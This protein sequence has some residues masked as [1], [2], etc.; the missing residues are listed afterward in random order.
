MGRDDVRARLSE[1]KVGKPLHPHMISAQRGAVGNPKTEE[2]KQ[3]ASERMRKIW[4][5]P[6]EHGL[7]ARRRWTDE[8]IAVLGTDHDPVI[9]ERLGVAPHIVEQK[10]RRLRIP[11]HV[12][13]WSD[14]EIALLGTNTDREVAETL[15]RT[16]SAV[17]TKRV[18]LG[19]PSCR[20][21]TRA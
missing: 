11:P 3:A 2:W 7:P 13:R 8:E 20:V 4:E 17:E 12:A 5:H 21:K 9:A 18:S 6:E 16:T 15:G 10:R 19:I 14:A 1:A